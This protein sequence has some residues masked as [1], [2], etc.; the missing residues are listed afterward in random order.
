MTALIDTPVATSPAAR[1]T[2]PAIARVPLGR[3]VAVELRKMFDTR[4]G[5]WLMASIGIVNVLA[6][7]AVIAFAPEK[8]QTYDNF[9]AAIGFPMAVILPMVAVLAVTGEFSQ[10]TGLTTFTLVPHRGPVLVAKALAS[11]AVAVAS[12][13]LA[14]AVGALG[15][16]VGTAISGAATVWD[17]SLV[18]AL[19]SCS[20]TSSG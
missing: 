17:I 14:F 8:A 20:A 19:R 16:L 15:N 9:A 13:V 4:A 18:H 2:R 7:V 1:G 6:T 5:F 12:M 10:R 3:V 11:L